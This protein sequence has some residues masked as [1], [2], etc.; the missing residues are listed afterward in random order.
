M[1]F[2]GRA[3]IRTA[4]SMAIC[5]AGGCFL[6]MLGMF[7]NAS[8]GGRYDGYDEPLFGTPGC[9]TRTLVYRVEILAEPM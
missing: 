5:I 1:L 3:Q 2:G 7:S 8:Q 6:V 4:S 9:E